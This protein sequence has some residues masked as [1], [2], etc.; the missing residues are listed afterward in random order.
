[1]VDPVAITEIVAALRAAGD[2]QRAAHAKRYLKSDLAHFGASVPATRRVVTDFARHQPGLARHDVV[3]LVEWLWAEPVH[4]RRM[5]VE[6][7][8]I[9]V[10]RLSRRTSRLWS[11]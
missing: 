2:S 11:G 5:A 9:Y 8:D 3:T 7:L 6:L 10:S 4:E 1:M